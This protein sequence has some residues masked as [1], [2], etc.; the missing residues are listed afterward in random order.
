M[1]VHNLPFLVPSH[2]AVGDFFSTVKV[3]SSEF[4]AA[5]SID[6]LFTNPKRTP[7]MF[8][9]FPISFFLNSDFN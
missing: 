2:E 8:L 9:G 5:L 3:S 1:Q 6:E 7:R 4:L